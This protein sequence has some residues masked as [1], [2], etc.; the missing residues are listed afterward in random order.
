[1]ESYMGEAVKGAGEY[2]TPPMK[3]QHRRHLSKEAF[4]VTPMEKT[5]D[6]F[7][8]F[9]WIARHA[10]QGPWDTKEICFN[11]PACLQN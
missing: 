7:L 3:L 5:V 10:P 9:W 11:S 6:I 8:P 1:M 2:Y 4:A